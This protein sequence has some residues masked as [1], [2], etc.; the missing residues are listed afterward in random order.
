MQKL[1]PTD[2]LPSP[3]LTKSR[4]SHSL[5][6]CQVSTLSLKA[7]VPGGCQSAVPSGP[8]APR[9]GFDDLHE[10]REFR[11]PG[12]HLQRQDAGDGDPGQPVTPLDDRKSQGRKQLIREQEPEAWSVSK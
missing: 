5:Y 8:A 2:M 7:A 10:Q 11:G 3:L 1:Y 6:F 4:R 9:E 12:R